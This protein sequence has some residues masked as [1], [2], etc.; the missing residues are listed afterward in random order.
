[1]EDNEGEGMYQA[2]DE[3]RVAGPVVKDLLI[4]LDG[5]S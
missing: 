4:L 1:M 3:H 2:K 5:A